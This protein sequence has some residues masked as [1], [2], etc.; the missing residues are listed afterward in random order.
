M[1]DRLK[2]RAVIV[3][4]CATGI[5]A[6]TV[7]RLVSEGA[8][9]CATDINV[10]GVEALAAE[11]AGQGHEVFAAEIDI[12]D[13]ASVGRGTAAA[14]ARFGGLDGALVNAADLGVI[15]RDSDLL[16]EP[17]EVFDRTIAVNLRGHMLCTR[18]VLPHLLARGRGAIVYTTSGAADAGEPTRPAYAIAK[19]GLNALMRHVARRWGPEGVT[20]NC[21]APGATDTPEKATNG[22]WPPELRARFLRE[23]PHTRLGWVDDIAAMAA[24]LLSKDGEWINGQVYNVNGGASMR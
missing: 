4:G 16:D 7:R 14:V 11:L 8:R 20:A 23:V 3:Y 17:M 15:A 13:E 22:R 18:A 19:S 10:P 1:Q 12:S 24:M 21:V 5:G 6:A 2:G 9:V